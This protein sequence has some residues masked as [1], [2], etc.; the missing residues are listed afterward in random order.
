MRTVFV[1]GAGASTDFHLPIGKALVDQI[2]NLLND[3]LVSTPSG[4]RILDAAI[5]S[6]LQ[7]DYREACQDLCGGLVAARSIDR[8]LESRK[9]RPLVKELGKCSI[10][11]AIGQK[12]AYSQLGEAVD[13][14]WASKHAGLLAS[15]ETWL[16]NLFAILAE[17]KH[18]SQSDQIFDNIAFVTFNYDRCIEQYLRLAFHHIMHLSYS[19]SVQIVSK[20]PITHVYGSLGELPDSNGNGG[21]IFGPDHYYIREMSQ[22]IRTF[23]EGAIDGT[24]NESRFHIQHADQIIFLGFGFDAM[25]VK[26]LFAGGLRESQALYGTRCGVGRAELDYFANEVTFNENWSATLMNNF[27]KEFTA[28]ED[29]RST[30]LRSAT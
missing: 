24:L 18:P 3:E 22:N 14:T 4:R 28:S 2:R 26:A 15:R 23:T 7:G 9:D 21:I 11:A 1:V 12:E 10:A 16:G 29:F 19:Q 8:L 6:Q 25:N 20:I 13:D 5:A 17:G 27:C 30:I